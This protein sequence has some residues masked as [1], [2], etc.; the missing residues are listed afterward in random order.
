[1]GP[2]GHLSRMEIQQ[3]ARLNYYSALE[4]VCTR[5]PMSVRLPGVTRKVGTPPHERST[6]SDAVRL[7]EELNQVRLQIQELRGTCDR[8]RAE[9]DQ[10]RHQGPT[11]VVVALMITY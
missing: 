9:L 11:I 8:I 6:P 10:C 4:A 5:S 2:H 1:M 7:E 3:C